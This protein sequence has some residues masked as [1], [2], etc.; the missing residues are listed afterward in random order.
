MK[1]VKVKITDI[2]IPRKYCRLEVNFDTVSLYAQNIENLPPIVINKHKRLIDGKHRIEAHKEKGLTEIEAT[3]IDI[4]D[5]Q[6]FIESIK[7]NNSHGKQLT[8]F[9]RVHTANKL[10]MGGV[11][12][13]KEI[14]NLLSVSYESAV[15]WTRQ[16]RYT[17]KIK[18]N[19][20]ILKMVEEDKTQEEIAEKLG[21]DQSR[22]SQIIND[23]KNTKTNKSEIYEDEGDWIATD[24]EVEDKLSK[25][26]IG[27][28]IDITIDSGFIVCNNCKQR[29][30]LVE[31]TTDGSPTGHRLI[32]Y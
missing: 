17:K 31:I 22:V 7:R 26:Q 3:I 19:E 11:E 30:K 1:M 13:L 23:S 9:D 18:R 4:P 28:E 10:Y 16:V 32:K 25:R 15:K 24:G 6:V 20:K 14:A 12:E 5:K 27:N 29:F 2:K 21:I 8:T